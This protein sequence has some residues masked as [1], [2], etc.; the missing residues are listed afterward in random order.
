MCAPALPVRPNSSISGSLGG[1]NCRLSDGT[2]F[3][4]Y[5]LTLATFGHL[6]LNAASDDFPATVILRDSVGRKLESGASIDRTIERGDYTVVVNT[7]SPEQSGKFTLNST[8]QPEPNTLCRDSSAVG[9]NQ[10]IAGRLVDASCLLPDNTPYDEY[11]V[12]TLGAGK[13]EIALVS[14]DFSGQL[15]LRD[16]AGRLIVSDGASISL[17]ATANTSYHIVAAGASPDARGDYKLSLKFTPGDGETCRPKKTLLTSED[18]TGT[19]AGDSCAYNVDQGT[20]YY[21]YYD[22][23]VTDAGV[24]ELSVTPGSEISTRLDILDSAGR[25]VAGDIQSGGLNRPALR[26]ELPPGTYS[27][28]VTAGQQVDYTLHFALNPGSPATCTTFSLRSGVQS[29]SFDATSS[30]RTSSALQDVYR[31]TLATPNTI[32]VQ[33]AS[34][35]LSGYLIL[36]DS[37]DNILVQN[38]G[39]VLADLK[40][41]T[42]TLRA[43][44]AAPGAYAINTLLK[45]QNLTCPGPVKIPSNTSGTAFLGGNNCR[46][47][48]GQYIDTYEFTNSFS[49]QVGVFMQSQSFD[50]YLELTDTAGTVL[51]RDDNSFGNGDAVI[52]QF[53]PAGTYRINASAS[54][55]LQ[56]GQYALYLFSNSGNRAPGCLPVADLTPGTLQRKLDITACQYYDGRF[57][58]VFRL[59]V[60]SATSLDVTMTFAQL[61]DAG[62]ELLDQKGNLVDVVDNSASGSSAHLTTQVAAGTYYV[63][64]KSYAITS[65]Y[66]LTVK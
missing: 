46:G 19:V 4:E 27:V 61:L 37:K 40:A 16:A 29:G 41:G 58:D 44:S 59:S 32:D 11:Q 21:N 33:I 12:S 9:L 26:L 54:G 31:F 52:L 2:A 22:L 43:Q 17:G 10:S 50:S 13:L 42:Y 35:V 28:L 15:I 65:S 63:V 23:T 48:D 3:V 51:R 7:Q 6:Q 14:T 64:A 18:V 60:P 55:G 62:L 49:G 20:L 1:A 66:T 34:N 8:F 57:A 38:S 39:E 47:A 25:L 45:G 5:P 24:A 56:S 36:A 30:C 53:L